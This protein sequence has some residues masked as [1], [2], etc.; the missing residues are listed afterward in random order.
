MNQNYS[1]SLLVDCKSLLVRRSY[2]FFNSFGAGLSGFLELTLNEENSLHMSQFSVRNLFY[3]YHC[4]KTAVC[5][6]SFVKVLFSYELLLQ[7]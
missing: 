7:T 4:N 5:S 2:L 6:L 1:D 3:V